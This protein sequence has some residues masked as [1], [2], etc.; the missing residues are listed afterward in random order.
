M[1]L[2]DALLTLVKKKIVTPD[3]A[4][5]KAVDKTGFTAQLK[6]GGFRISAE[7]PTGGGPGA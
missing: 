6:A 3:E 5:T 2:N 7:K 4:L 1:L